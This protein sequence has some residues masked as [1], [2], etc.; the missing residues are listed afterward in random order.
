MKGRT[1][2]ETQ[3]TF[4]GEL[5]RGDD[6][7]DVFL[8]DKHHFTWAVDG[9]VR[10]TFFDEPSG[11]SDVV[12]IG[13]DGRELPLQRI[14]YGNQFDARAGVRYEVRVAGED[15]FAQPTYK[16]SLDPA[17]SRAVLA[18]VRPVPPPPTIEEAEPDALLDKRIAEATKSWSVVGKP[19]RIDLATKQRKFVRT[20]KQGRCYMAMI[21][22]DAGARLD[23]PD[24]L[25]FRLRVTDKFATHGTMGTFDTDSRRILRVGGTV[26]A[27]G[28][29]AATPGGVELIFGN[30]GR[31]TA[32][33]TVYEHSTDLKQLQER[34]IEDEQDW[35][36]GCMD[37]RLDCQRTGHTGTFSTCAQQFKA[38]IRGLKVRCDP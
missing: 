28:L 37:E 34:A 13:P 14:L 22:M 24:D 3:R 17:P 32:V 38:C 30:T 4:E 15:R 2:E 1:I 33:A 6:S 7:C 8:C 10:M 20:A 36:T 27:E 5:R 11:R 26:G 21:R 25:A 31:G 23:R 12:V 19:Q 16:L 29:C 9:P 35:C 18:E